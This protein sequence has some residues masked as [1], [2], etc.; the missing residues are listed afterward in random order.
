MTLK[1]PD[2]LAEN[3]GHADHGN[4]HHWNGSARGTE[5]PI[6]GNT[7][8]AI[9]G[10]N[11]SPIEG[12]SAMIEGADTS[13]GESLDLALAD[14]WPGVK[15]VASDRKP[16]SPEAPGAKAP[17]ARGTGTP[18]TRRTSDVVPR[19]T[20]H[21]EHTDPEKVRLVAE[22]NAVWRRLEDEEEKRTRL[23]EEV[24]ELHSTLAEE[25]RARSAAA[26]EKRAA[27]LREAATLREARKEKSERAKLEHELAEMRS[28]LSAQRPK[29]VAGGAATA[30]GLLGLALV[31]RRA[32]RKNHRGL[33][34]WQ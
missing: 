18:R 17:R 3:S 1:P 31:V 8:S 15:I 11:A 10:N 5:F 16:E 34:L 14:T 26:R 13:S 25:Q 32:L 24:D 9:E 12:T 28:Q 23:A 30:G 4:S 20:T 6:E 22:V 2:L 33:K 29:L 27:E 21:N 19:G 7:A